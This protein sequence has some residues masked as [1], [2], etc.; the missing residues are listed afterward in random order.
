MKEMEPGEKRKCEEKENA[1]NKKRKLT[2]IDYMRKPK[3]N[4]RKEKEQELDPDPEVIYGEYKK[5]GM[6]EK[7]FQRKQRDR[8]RA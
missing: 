4:S 1:N 2:I 3:E 8:R 7:D 6:M 5:G